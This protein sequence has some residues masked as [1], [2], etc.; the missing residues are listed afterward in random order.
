MREP[1]VLTAAEAILE[2]QD[3]ALAA[4]PAVFL[5]GEGAADPKGIFGTTA[6]LVDKYGPA[7]VMEMPVSENGFTGIAV[8]AAL[9]G[10]RPVVIHQRVEFC[11]LAM[12]QLFGNA[13]KA[14]YVS[15]GR[16][17]AP[18]VVRLVAGRGWGQGPQHGQVLENLFALVPG[19]KLVLPAGPADAK[20]ML[21][22]AIADDNPVIFLEHRWV[23]Y[24]SG[25][26]PE[27]PLPAPLDGPRRI[28]AGGDV[29]VVAA[30]YMT[31]ETRHAAAALAAEG[32]A[33]DLFDLRVARPL[34]TDAIQESVR[35]TGR[36]L[37]VDTGWKTFGL[38]AEIVARVTESCFADMAAPPRRVGLPDHPT[39]SSR[40]LAEAYY[41]RAEHVA[42]AIGALVGLPDARVA[43]VHA[44]LAAER[45]QVPLDIPHP[46]FKG[47]F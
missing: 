44:T 35:R 12:E 4:D 39:P 20:G 21:L 8:G 6:G 33:V 19:L 14:H 41:P 3:Q 37:V 29:T 1:R 43:A 32:V 27:A 22:A 5:M 30:S 17:R 15:D 34:V 10:R 45:R 25:E 24:V 42:G 28:L 36:L 46:S 9:M 18:L 2:A 23:H 11:L 31:L 26:V 13:A 7:R 47:P 16:H 38:G 40:A